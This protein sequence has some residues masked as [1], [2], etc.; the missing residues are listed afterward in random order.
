MKGSSGLLKIQLILLAPTR[1]ALS[2]SCAP[3][4][5]TRKEDMNLLCADADAVSWVHRAEV[6]MKKSRIQTSHSAQ[7]QRSTAN[8]STEFEVSVVEVAKWKMAMPWRTLDESRAAS[9]Q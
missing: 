6:E 1:V 4:D 5:Q 3:R 8:K 2:P 7:H 9:T